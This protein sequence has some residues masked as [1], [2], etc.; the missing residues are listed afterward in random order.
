MSPDAQGIAPL[1]YAILRIGE[2][3]MKMQPVALVAPAEGEREYSTTPIGH[4]L[5]VWLKRAIHQSFGGTLSEP[6][7][8]EL[9]DL[10][11]QSN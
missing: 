11:L 7:P 8:P 10:V 9:L 6:I 2:M 5:D 4:A 3:A 1:C